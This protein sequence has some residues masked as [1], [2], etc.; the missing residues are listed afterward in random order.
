MPKKNANHVNYTIRGKLIQKL[1]LIY[2][3][4]DTQKIKGSK[5]NL[6]WQLKLAE[7]KLKKLTKN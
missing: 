6:Q 4:K 7:I 1:N 3:S 2:H 5:N